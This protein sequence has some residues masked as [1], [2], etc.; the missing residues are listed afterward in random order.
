MVTTELP[1]RVLLIDIASR[2]VLRD[3][4]TRGKTSHMVTLGP[5]AAWAYVSN[6]TSASVSAVNL[7][8]GAVVV[9]PCGERPEGSVLSKDGATYSSPTAKRNPSPSSIRRRT[10]PWVPSRPET[11]R[12][13][14]PSRPDGKSLVYAA[15]HDHAVE[16]ADPATRKVTGKVPLPAKSGIISLHVSGDGQYA[17]AAAEED[18]TVY[19]VSI[20]DRKLVRTIK[21]TEGF[22]PDPAVWLAH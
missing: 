22:A 4:D 10:S 1:D 15:M 18:D 7:Q 8:T 20:P 14:S 19:V 11:A 21:V 2:K 5:G 13:G 6:S 16:F 3:F 9:I 17:T 12:F